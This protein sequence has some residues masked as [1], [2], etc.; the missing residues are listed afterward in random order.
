MRAL[1]EGC[2]TSARPQERAYE[3]CWLRVHA[4][5]QSDLLR[6]CQS[7]LAHEACEDEQL[8]LVQERCTLRL[9]YIK[10]SSTAKARLLAVF[11]YI[12]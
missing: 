12:L 11:E 7:V 1:F 9:V 10:L 6:E 2:E 5:Q 8:C 3:S 4:L